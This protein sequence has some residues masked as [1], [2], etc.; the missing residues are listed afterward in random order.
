MGCDVGRRQERFWRPFPKKALP[1]E[2]RGRKVTGLK[3]MASAKPHDSG[4]AGVDMN[5]FRHSFVRS[6]LMLAVLVS[7]ISLVQAVETNKNGPRWA[8]WYESN[9]LTIQCLLSRA[10]TAPSDTG[11]TPVI[12]SR[13]PALVRLIWTEPEQL[14][15]KRIKIPLISVPYEM[16]FV[17]ELAESVMCGVRRD[18]SLSFDTN[19]D[20][21][22]PVRA[23]ALQAGA[24]EIQVMA[25]LANQG[26][27]LAAFNGPV[28]IEQKEERRSTRRRR[29]LAS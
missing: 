12:D 24:S 10:P 17:R 9:D 29:T 6:L 25:E 18:C 7:S 16:S 26:L 21:R 5:A 13:L 2:R 20:G 28:A 19:A 11:T 3:G 27:V 23:A 15:E 22:A 1:S 4:I 8:C 14:G